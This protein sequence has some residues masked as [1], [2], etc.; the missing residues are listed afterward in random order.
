M[1]IRSNWW[2]DFQLRWRYF[3]DPDNPFIAWMLIFNLVLLLIHLIIVYWVYRDA[4]TRYNRGAP[5][6]VLAAVLPVAGWL[7]YLLYRISPL[8]QFDRIEAELFDEREQE[9]TDYDAQR[10]SQG[11]VLFKEISSLWR[12]PEGLGPS[13]KT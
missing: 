6:A 7:F 9:W 12:K 1:D 3:F 10:T 13:G 5:W 8:V 11:A 4:M 2:A